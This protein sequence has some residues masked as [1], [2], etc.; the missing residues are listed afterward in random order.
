MQLN[1]YQELAMH[2][3]AYPLIGQNLIYPVLGLT[4]EA[5]ELANKL[6]KVLRG[7]RE[8]DGPFVLDMIAELGD[9]LWYVAAVAKEIGMDLDWIAQKNLD[10]LE[11]R[12]QRGVI[13]GEGDKR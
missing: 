6:K 3:A 2:Y 1:K 11:I 4:G 13:K 12:A 10:K 5:G 7:D 8:Y 9:V